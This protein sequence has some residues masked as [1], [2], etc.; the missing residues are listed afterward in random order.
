MVLGPAIELHRG[1]H[2]ALLEHPPPGVS[3]LQRPHRYRYRFRAADLPANP[4]DQLAVDEAVDYDLPL[5]PVLVH[6]CRLPVANRVPW[7]IDH[8]DM[9]AALCWGQFYAVGSESRIRSGQ[10]DRKAWRLRQ[11]LLLVR[12]LRPECQAVLF[13]TE[14]ARRSALEYL[15]AAG[16][17]GPADVE[18]IEAK[19]DVVYPA[20]PPLPPTGARGPAVH[21]L[22]AGRTLGDKGGDVALEVFRRLRLRFGASIDLT[23]VGNDRHR[24]AA[25]DGIRRRPVLPRHEYLQLL[26]QA[27]V[28]FMPTR[29]ESFGMALLEAAA[30]GLPI[31]TSCGEGME[32]VGEVLRD[33]SH[34]RL[35]PNQWPRAARVEAYTR[36]LASLVADEPAR[37]AMGANARALVERGPFSLPVRDRK[38]SAHYARALDWRPGRG[39][40]RDVRAGRGWRLEE[41][42][43]PEEYG[44]LEIGRRRGPGHFRIRL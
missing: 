25:D 29:F 12:H 38:V 11:R 3:Y 34:G 36:A 35:V 39:R 9:V 1:V 18:A 15:R 41:R 44:W 14:H 10:V 28:F 22:C 30:V 24:V 31:V 7:V 23:L 33:G 4:F 17:C 37:R 16:L 2:G 21:V 27:H 20:L 32:H 19:S 40:A 6:S 43:F 5:G 26:R 42:D 8:D 13:W